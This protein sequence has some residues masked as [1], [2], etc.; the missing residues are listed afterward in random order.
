MACYAY[1]SLEFYPLLCTNPCIEGVL[2]F[3][4]LGN[5]IRCFNKFSWGV[6]TSENYM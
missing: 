3:T 1:S 6:A 5:E 4:H 2:Y